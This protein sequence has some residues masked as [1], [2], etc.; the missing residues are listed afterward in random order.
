MA[1]PTSVS[2][3]E[4]L[5]YDWVNF[6][7][8]EKWEPGPGMPRSEGNPC[9]RMLQTCATLGEAVAFFRT[10]HEPGFT[11]SRILVADKTGASAIIGVKDG[12]LFVDPANQCRGFGYGRRTLN[13]MLAASSEPTVANGIE[14]LRRCA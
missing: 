3:I 9:E 4:G 8:N 6:G 12:E 14:I 11:T 2:I 1:A 13:D 5:A 10:H 7:T